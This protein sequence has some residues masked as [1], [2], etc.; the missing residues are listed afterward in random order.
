MSKPVWECLIYWC[1]YHHW[2]S[3]SLS[4]KMNSITETFAETAMSGENTSLWCKAYLKSQ[5][6]LFRVGL[7]CRSPMSE[8]G[9]SYW[10]LSKTFSLSLSP[11]LSNI[12]WKN[13][14]KW[15]W[16]GMQMNLINSIVHNQNL[17]SREHVT[18]TSTLLTRNKGFF[19]LNIKSW[20]CR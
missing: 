7:E 17:F 16:G 6:F 2:L 13:K 12:W 4:C 8:A 14:Y 15:Y 11:P 1:M 10:V 9:C 5:I 20:Q 3:L 19:L 18:I